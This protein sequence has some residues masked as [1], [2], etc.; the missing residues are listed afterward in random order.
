MIIGALVLLKR[1]EAN[2]KIVEKSV[3]KLMPMKN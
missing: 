2:E 1:P 3:A